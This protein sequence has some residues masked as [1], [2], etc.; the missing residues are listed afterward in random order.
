MALGLQKESNDLLDAAATEFPTERDDVA[1]KKQR[2]APK[3][4]IHVGAQHEIKSI[5]FA[6]QIAP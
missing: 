5:A 6:V 3:V 2:L 4:V 1:E